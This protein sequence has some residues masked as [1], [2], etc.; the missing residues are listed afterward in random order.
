MMRKLRS[1]MRSTWRAC[2]KYASGV[3]SSVGSSEKSSCSAWS[4][5]NSLPTLAFALRLS[6]RTWGA[7]SRRAEPLGDDLAPH[8]GELARRVQQ[9]LSFSP[10]ASPEVVEQLLRGRCAARRRAP[11]G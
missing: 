10:S 7:V 6:T 3:A 5:A 8:S 2:V 1:S 9:P 11:P 4:W